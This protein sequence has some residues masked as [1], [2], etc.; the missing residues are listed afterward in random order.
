MLCC[1]FAAHANNGNHVYHAPLV[2]FTESSGGLRSSTSSSSHH[3]STSNLSTMNGGGSEAPLPP[4]PPRQTIRH[5]V[6]YP[7]SRRTPS[8]APPINR[9]PWPDPEPDP[10]TPKNAQLEATA[11]T[12]LVDS[13]QEF[14]KRDENPDAPAWQKN[15]FKAANSLFDRISEASKRPPREPSKEREPGIL[16]SVL[17][18]AASR[19]SS[20]TRQPQGP[21]RLKKCSSVSGTCC[22]CVCFGV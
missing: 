16:T 2:G 9:E 7:G 20:V 14:V 5:A 1:A 21:R 18:G 6:P 4:R 11:L 17:M 13:I 10:T 3:R 19:S 12:E 8:G 15:F 22:D